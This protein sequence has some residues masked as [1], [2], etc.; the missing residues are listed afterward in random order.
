[1]YREDAL[2]DNGK[3]V[4]IRRNRKI[5]DAKEVTKRE[6]Q[7]IARELLGAVDTQAQQPYSLL[8]VEQFIENRFKADVVWALKHAGKLHYR[9][10][11]DKQ[12]I[13]ALGHLRLREVTSDP[14]QEL[15][16]RK[17]DDGYSVQT[18]KHIKNA[19]SAVFRHAKLKRAYQGDNPA[20]G[21]RMPEM[22][23]R[24]THDLMFDQ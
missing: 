8:T 1:A 15:V 3:L 9:H 10:M 23:R 14:V 21:V 4:R 11:L 16:R 7:R 22:Q 24:E 13:P 2:D 18:V 6:A 20:E 5:A 19:V 12:V 17:I